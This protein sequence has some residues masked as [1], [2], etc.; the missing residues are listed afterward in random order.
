[1]KW[2]TTD[3]PVDLL[4]RPK[5]ATGATE[6][7]PMPGSRDL[8]KSGTAIDSVTPPVKKSATARKGAVASAKKPTAKVA[9]ATK[10][11]TAA[12]KAKGAVKPDAKTAKKP[13]EA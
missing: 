2:N 1:M 9:S 6:A 10:T 4:G 12:V 13:V 7:L 11:K 8:A 5:P 3:T